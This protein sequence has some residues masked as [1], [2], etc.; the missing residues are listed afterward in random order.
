MVPVTATQ[1]TNDTNFSQVSPRRGH[2]GTPPATT[3]P[4]NILKKTRKAW[5]EE[6]AKGRIARKV[7]PLQANWKMGADFF[8]V[9]F[10]SFQYP[11]LIE[12]SETYPRKPWLSIGSEHF[13][14]RPKN[15]AASH[16]WLLLAEMSQPVF[17]MQINVRTKRPILSHT[18]SISRHDGDFQFNFPALLPIIQRTHR[19]TSTH[20]ELEPIQENMLETSDFRWWKQK[21]SKNHPKHAKSATSAIS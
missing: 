14:H 5:L 19:I 12:Y 4:K 1:L 17:A 3:M 8:L 16:D 20:W 13:V 21:T 9:P 2:P 7:V 6:K 10:I 18:K 15:Q 11:C